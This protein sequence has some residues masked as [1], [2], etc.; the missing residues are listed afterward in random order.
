[1][2]HF[3]VKIVTGN[4]IRYFTVLETD[5][6]SAIEKVLTA[7]NIDRSECDIIDVRCNGQV[8]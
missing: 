3:N 1:M 8:V 2:K 5:R 7:N 6:E 4:K